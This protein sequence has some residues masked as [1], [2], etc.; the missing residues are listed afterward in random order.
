[1]STS[2][3]WL[4]WLIVG[5]EAAFWVVLVLALAIRYLL[6]LPQLS[7]VFLWSLPGIDLLLLIFTA[8]DLHG[9]TVAT[10]AHGLATAYVGFTL[11]F[12]GVLVK[13]ADQRFAHRFAGGS[14][15]TPAPTYGWPAVRYEFALWF[16]CILAWVIALALLVA[17]IAFVDDSQK[18]R[19]LQVWPHAAVSTTFLWFFFGPVW[20]LVFFRRSAES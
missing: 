15:P 3:A 19:Q 1:M 12:G 9:G 4:Y 5:C 6:K 18:T 17:L 10:I 16:R 20:R 13:W 8:M 7:R 14:A 11:A 2:S